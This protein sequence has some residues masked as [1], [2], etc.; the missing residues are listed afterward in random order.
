ML[1]CRTEL[2]SYSNQ[3]LRCWCCIM[4]KHN[5]Y[6]HNDKL[7]YSMFPRNSFRFKFLP[8]SFLAM[9]LNS[10][11]QPIL[12]RLFSLYL[13]FSLNPSFSLSPSKLNVL[14]WLKMLQQKMIVIVRNWNPWNLKILSISG[15]TGYY[16]Q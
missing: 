4:F 15:L 3:D 5:F 12:L 8:Y 13:F 16:G 1:I 6:I 2:W 14:W 7:L 11:C 9:F 10:F